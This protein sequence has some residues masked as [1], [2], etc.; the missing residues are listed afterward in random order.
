MARQVIAAGCC[1]YLNIRCRALRGVD[2]VADELRN[3]ELER[4]NY[5]LCR[6][7]LLGGPRRNDQIASI[8]GAR[9]C[10]DTYH[11]DLIERR[12]V[13]SFEGF[14]NLRGDSE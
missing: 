2:L 1:S 13:P 8:V 5:V 4:G 12:E 10:T 11:G 9:V 3:D 7:T 14:V 6:L